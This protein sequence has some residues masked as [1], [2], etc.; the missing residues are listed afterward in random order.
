VSWTEFVNKQ[1]QVRLRR[2]DPTGSLSPALAVGVTMA[3]QYPRLAQG[4]D[5]LLVTWI[6][7]ED[8]RIG[9]AR[10]PLKRQ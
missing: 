3:M 7:S 2:V 1:Q 6:K 10:V 9:T 5:E 4:Q 8:L